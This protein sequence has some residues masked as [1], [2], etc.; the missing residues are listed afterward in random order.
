MANGQEFMSGEKKITLTWLTQAVAIL[1][2]IGAVY[3]FPVIPQPKDTTSATGLVVWGI[4]VLALFIPTII[5]YFSTRKYVGDKTKQNIEAIKADAEVQ[6]AVVL[7][8]ITTVTPSVPQVV[9]I[10]PNPVDLDAVLKLVE[11]QLTSQVFETVD[12]AI[13]RSI[14]FNRWMYDNWESIPQFDKARLVSKAIEL[15]KERYR[16]LVGAE[17]P[18]SGDVLVDYNKFIASI[19]DALSAKYGCSG[20]P[21]EAV[22]SAVMDLRSLYFNLGGLTA[23]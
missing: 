16:F 1:N 10:Q 6:K 23:N 18:V 17:A 11:G 21:V 12:P 2:T 4:E 7:Q 5:T 9:P 3:A 13:A 20:Y 15:A 8:R 19:R 22:R 14:I